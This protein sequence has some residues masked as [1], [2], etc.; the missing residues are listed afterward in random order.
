M[1]HHRT[2]RVVRPWPKPV[3]V[4]AAQRRRRRHRQALQLLVAAILS[5]ALLALLWLATAPYAGR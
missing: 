3:Y 4:L 5:A 2:K 1:I